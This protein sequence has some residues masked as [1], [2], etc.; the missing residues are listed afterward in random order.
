VSKTWR[1]R[2]SKRGASEGEVDRRTGATHLR[3]EK[4]LEVEDAERGSCSFGSGER[5]AD[6]GMGA[7]LPDEGRSL[8][9]GRSPCT[10]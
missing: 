3:V 5:G 9:G 1:G 2:N 4:G 7:V 10:G 6:N 8:H